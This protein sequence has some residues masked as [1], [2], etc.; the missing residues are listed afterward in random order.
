MILLAAMLLSG[1]GAVLIFFV[2]IQA[3]IREERDAVSSLLMAM[4][5]PPI[6]MGLA[7]VFDYVRTQ[8]NLETGSDSYSKNDSSAK[9]AASDLKGTPWA[10][11]SGHTK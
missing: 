6:L 7:I 3:I 2:G 8:I 4:I 10:S 5:V 9:A 1:F 11:D